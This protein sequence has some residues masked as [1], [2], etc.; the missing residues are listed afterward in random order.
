MN[1]GGIT[2]LLAHGKYF[3]RSFA[4]FPPR[5]LYECPLPQVEMTA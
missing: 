3:K 1:V 2:L 5:G 4:T